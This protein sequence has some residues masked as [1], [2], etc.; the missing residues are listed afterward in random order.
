MKIRIRV[1][2][3]STFFY[4]NCS[5]GQTGGLFIGKYDKAFTEK[6]LISYSCNFSNDTLIVK[7]YA[8]NE[9]ETIK[10]TFKKLIGGYMNCDFQEYIY[11]C[12][13]CYQTYIDQ[14]LKFKMYGFKAISNDKYLS[15]Y[16]FHT[17]LD[18]NQNKM[19]LKLTFNYVDKTKD[20]YKKWYESLK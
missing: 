9:T 20:D 4:F 19:N 5:L 13:E 14:Y 2:F 6:K 16:K 7:A 12:S 15:K 1:F 18:I 11:D 17:T 10:L 3:I 8:K